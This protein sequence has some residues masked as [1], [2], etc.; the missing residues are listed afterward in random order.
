M[1]EIVERYDVT[2]MPQSIEMIDNALDAL[3]NSVR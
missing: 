3:S 2:G 1:S